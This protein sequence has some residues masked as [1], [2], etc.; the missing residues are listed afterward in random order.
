MGGLDQCNASAPPRLFHDSDSPTHH[1]HFHIISFI[2]IV[3][4]TL[5]YLLCSETRSSETSQVG[6]N[7]ESCL[8]LSIHQLLCFSARSLCHSQIAGE[9]DLLPP[10]YI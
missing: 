6:A 10:A 2:L 1:H 4:H 9:G 5:P 8:K 3:K 7:P